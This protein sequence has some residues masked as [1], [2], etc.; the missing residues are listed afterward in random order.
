MVYLSDNQPTMQLPLGGDAVAVVGAA[1]LTFLSPIT[2]AQH[3]HEEPS[4]VEE[5]TDPDDEVLGHGDSVADD[6]DD[7]DDDDDD[8]FDDDKPDEGMDAP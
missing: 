2:Y 1:P 8:D 6:I 7:D 3:N 5:E 4:D